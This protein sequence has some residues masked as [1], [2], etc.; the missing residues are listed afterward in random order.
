[1]SMRS[2]SEKCAN[3]LIMAKVPRSVAS[4][5]SVGVCLDRRKVSD[6]VPVDLV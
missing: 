5:G 1:M 3:I 2:I 4:T 6:F